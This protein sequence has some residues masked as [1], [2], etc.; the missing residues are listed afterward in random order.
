MQPELVAQSI[1]E[2]SVAEKK[3]TSVT[4]PSHRVTQSQDLKAILEA[5]DVQIALLG[6]Q[7]A[8]LESNLEQFK[9]VTAVSASERKDANERIQS[10][11]DRVTEMTAIITAL[12]DKL[13]NATKSKESISGDLDFFKGQ[14][15]NASMMAVE[16]AQRANA[17]E[18]QVATLRKQLDIGL[19]QKSLHYEAIQRKR[20]EENVK[21][22]K[23]TKL[24]LDQARLTDDTVRAKAVAFDALKIE[25]AALVKDNEIWEKNYDSLQMRNEELVEQLTMLRG[26]RMGVFE[27]DSDTESDDEHG[28]ETDADLAGGEG[29]LGSRYVSPSRS[30]SIKPPIEVDLVYGAKLHQQD[31]MSTDGYTQTEIMPGESQLDIGQSSGRPKVAVVQ[32]RGDVASDEVEGG[33]GF[34]CKWNAGHGQCP[35]MFDTQQVGAKGNR[36]MWGC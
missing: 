5:K 3:A 20:E 17:L 30:T 34:V 32:S 7:V 4:T 22:R 15:Q 35:M 27:E 1:P 18:E 13:Q 16:N 28:A 9:T 29:Y 6:N 14:Y 10:L 25:N 12:E 26:K 36:L 24:L 33:L 11:I 8:E 21:L 2:I 23:Q 31:N 19:K